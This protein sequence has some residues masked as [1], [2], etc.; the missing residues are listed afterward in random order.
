MG[1]PMGQHPI[2]ITYSQKPKNDPKVGRD[3]VISTSS[4]DPPSIGCQ[5]PKIGH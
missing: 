3:P 5:S 2:P 1:E 4:C